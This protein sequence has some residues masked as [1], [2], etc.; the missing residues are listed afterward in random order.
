T[1]ASLFPLSTDSATWQTL[2]RPGTRVD[3]LNVSS[4]GEQV[5]F[6]GAPMQHP[7]YL[8]NVRLPPSKAWF[9][10]SQRHLDFNKSERVAALTGNAFFLENVV[11]LDFVNA[12][13][14]V[15]NDRLAPAKG[16]F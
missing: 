14:G 12:R 4:W 9:T 11:V 7:A 13:F 3:T 16:A 6:Y 1:G 10:R 5:A 2:V 8:G 15:V